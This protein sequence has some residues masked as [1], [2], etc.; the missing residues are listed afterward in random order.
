MERSIDNFAPV[1]K[2]EG[3]NRQ[4]RARLKALCTTV[5]TPTFASDIVLAISRLYSADTAIS[6]VNSPAAKKSW[7]PRLLGG[8]TTDTAPILYIFQG[9]ART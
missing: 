9:I 8:M 5:R 3:V 4:R 1:A 6:T 2:G 7:E